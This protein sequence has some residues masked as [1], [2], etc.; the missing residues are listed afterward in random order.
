M[1]GAGPGGRP[2]GAGNPD[3]RRMKAG[4]GKVHALTEKSLRKIP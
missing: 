2:S 1:T 3:V 4:T